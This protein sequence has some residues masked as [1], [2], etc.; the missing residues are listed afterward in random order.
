MNHQSGKCWL[1]KTVT[2]ISK[3]VTTKTN[4]KKTGTVAVIIRKLISLCTEGSLLYKKRGN[5]ALTRL[6]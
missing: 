4:K 6:P 1:F 2:V 3:H 5:D